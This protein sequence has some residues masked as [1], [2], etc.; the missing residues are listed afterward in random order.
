M[1]RQ[2]HLTT[3]FR[4]CSSNARSFYLDG[5]SFLLFRFSEA[6]VKFALRDSE[7]ILG[8]RSSDILQISRTFEEVVHFLNF[9]EIKSIN[10]K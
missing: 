7:L 5:R 1:M 6:I 4:A 9:I 3:P 2:S 8:K 10:E